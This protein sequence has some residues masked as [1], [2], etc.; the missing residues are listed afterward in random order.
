M[1]TTLLIGADDFTA[2]GVAAAGAR[3]RFTP[4]KLS[5]AGL[6]LVST[7]SW[8]VTLDAEGNGVTEIPDAAPGEG[9]IIWSSI[10]GWVGRP[11]VAGYPADESGGAALYLTDLLSMYQVDPETLAATA[12]PPAAWWTALD[13]VQATADAALPAAQLWRG[14][15]AQ[16]A[17]IATKDPNTVYV[18]AG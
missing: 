15:A 18:V 2:S 6:R 7:R 1:T 3:F 13:G 8:Q 11:T 5:T 12:N 4:V 17:A 16:Y 9:L 14:T 10:E